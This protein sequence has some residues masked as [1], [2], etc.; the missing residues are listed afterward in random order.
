[1]NSIP[2]DIDKVLAT[3]IELYRHQKKNDI[4]N[5][6][7]NAKSKI[8]ETSYDN[9]NGGTYFYSLSLDIPV[10]IF[11][12]IESNLNKYEKEI[13]SKLQVVLRDT[14]NSILNSVIIRPFI[15]QYGEIDLKAEPTEKDI[16][17]IWGSGLLKAFISHQHSDKLHAAHLKY[18]LM[19][20]K[21]AA[22]VA[23]EDIEPTLLW[24]K[25][26]KK[27]LNSM[28]IFIALLSSQYRDSKWTDQEIGYAVAKKVL[29]IHVRDGQD[30]YG[31]IGETQSLSMQIENSENLALGIVNILVKNT[32]IRD[33]MRETL[34]VALENSNGFQIACNI[35]RIIENMDGGV[36]KDEIKRIKN[37]ADNNSRVKGAYTVINFLERNKEALNEEDDP[38]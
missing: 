17:Q 18:Q 24:Q 6:L 38:F 7:I 11:S 35:M 10:E 14:G 12:S 37:A 33:K 20:F 23:H 25:E 36:S 28:D 34:F 22:F 1:M 30:P 16:K 9:W 8:E 26:I 31:F 27:A 2:F 15:V 4:I 19:K 13:E 3:L 21:I 5:I 32:S 29:I